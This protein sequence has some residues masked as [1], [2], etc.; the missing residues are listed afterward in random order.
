MGPIPPGRLEAIHSESQTAPNVVVDFAHTPDALEKVLVALKQTCLGELTCLVG[1]GGDR[2]KGKRSQ[3]AEVA[4]NYADHVWFTSDNPRSEAAGDI[5]QDMVTGLSQEELSRCNIE[6]DRK[7]AIKQA[8]ASANR[9]DVVL[10]AGKG[11]ETTQEVNGKKY[12]FDD[13]QVAAQVLKE[14]A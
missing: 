2:D 11:H 10:L 12:A 5:I 3:M 7:H 1:C 9:G 8:I 4:V 14:V 13:R 6:E